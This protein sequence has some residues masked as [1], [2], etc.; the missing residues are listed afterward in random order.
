MSDP[1]AVPTNKP[2]VRSLLLVGGGV[3]LVVAVIAG[4][5]VPAIVEAKAKVRITSCASNL[6]HMYTM[7]M[8]YAM[9]FGGETKEY[10]TETGSAFWLKLTK[11][12]PPLLD[13]DVVEILLC[14]VLGTT[15]LGTCEYLGPSQAYKSIA[16]G[17]P[18]GA[19]RKA[20]HQRYGGG[21]ILRKSGDVLSLPD[22]DFLSVCDKLSP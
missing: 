14:P 20:N 18:V 7:Q 15:A 11:T 8:T 1:A 6:R 3:V 2:S 5:L 22:A 9:Q 10:P 13:K 17:D 12:T 4:L 19:D 16:G 21:N